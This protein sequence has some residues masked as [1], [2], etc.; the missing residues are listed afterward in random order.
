[1]KVATVQ[2]KKRALKEDKVD[3]PPK[4][5]CTNASR[6]RNTVNSYTSSSKSDCVM[7]QHSGTTNSEEKEASNVVREGRKLEVSISQSG[8]F[9]RTVRLP[10]RFR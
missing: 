9:G 8:R 4:R 1:V 3:Q 7:V 6:K 10:T 2:L 5:V